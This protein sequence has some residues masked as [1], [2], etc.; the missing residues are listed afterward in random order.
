M[1]LK[2]KVIS[3]GALE[4][5]LK[6]FQLLHENIRREKYCYYSTVDELMSFWQG[7]DGAYYDDGLIYDVLTKM[8]SKPRGGVGLMMKAIM[9]DGATSITCSLE[10]QEGKEVTN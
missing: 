6:L 2:L 5:S 9:A 10:L 3:V 1:G 7:R 8:K 4:G